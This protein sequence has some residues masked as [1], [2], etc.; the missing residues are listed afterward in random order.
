M[1]VKLKFKVTSQTQQQAWNGPGLIGSVKLSPVMGGSDENK[2]FYEATP[3]GSIEFSTINAAAL[4]SLPV[5]AEV[6]VTLEVAQ[7]AE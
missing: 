3:G 1:N 5:G 7:A 4:A 2:S 6:Y